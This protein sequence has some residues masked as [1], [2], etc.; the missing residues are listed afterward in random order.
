MFARYALSG[1][2]EHS[3]DWAVIRG[4]EITLV[5]TIDAGFDDSKLTRR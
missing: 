3:K 4:V 1:L 2:F 5:V